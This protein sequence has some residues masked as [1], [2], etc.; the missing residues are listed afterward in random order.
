MDVNEN[1]DLGESDYTKASDSENAAVKVAGEELVAAN[2]T[3][4]YKVSI[5]VKLSRYDKLR[6]SSQ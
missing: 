6:K 1:T 5:L 3:G 2:P 4:M